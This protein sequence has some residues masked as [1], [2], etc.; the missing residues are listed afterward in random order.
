MKYDRT[1]IAYHGCAEA[2]VGQIL[3]GAPFTP[4]ENDY[5]WLGSGIYF[6][7]FGRDR[8]FQFARSK[9]EN[10]A[11][12]GAVLQLGNCFDLMDTRH[13]EE[14]AA[15]WAT[16][17]KA[18]Q[19]LRLPLPQNEGRTRDKK[20]RRRDCAVINFCLNF[21]QYERGVAYDSVRC[22]FGEGAP[23]YP[24]SGIRRESHVQIAVRNPACILGVFRPTL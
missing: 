24:G 12:V 15:A 5:D 19:G 20:L 2:T 1:V 3:S 14:L 4:S 16:F 23:V 21:L 6:W 9:A 18:Q 7:E 8:A 22:M 11:V 17:R 10:P 13:T